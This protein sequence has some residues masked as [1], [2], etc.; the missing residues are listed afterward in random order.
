MGIW[1]INMQ[2]EQVCNLKLNNINNSEGLVI[3]MLKKVLG[4]MNLELVIFGFY[5]R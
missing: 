5:R 4:T 2:L 3:L 1:A